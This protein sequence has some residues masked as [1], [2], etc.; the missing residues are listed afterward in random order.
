MT[1]DGHSETYHSR[2]RPTFSS[3]LMTDL[4]EL[5]MA[6]AYVQNN[7]EARATFELFVRHLPHHRN[8]LVAAG[9]DQALDFLEN[10]H[11]TDDEIAY[12]ES[13]PLFRKVGPQFFEYLRRFRFTGEVWAMPEGTPFFPG[14]PV[15]PRHS[16]HCRSP[17]D[18]NKPAIDRPFPNAHRQQS[19]ASDHGGWQ[20]SCN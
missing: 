14:E 16:S 17:V 2:E 8:Y 20:N 4:Y 11:F 1:T 3:G 15:A 6:A 19:G 12:L 9:L 10:V 5:T 7:F 13:L 18:G